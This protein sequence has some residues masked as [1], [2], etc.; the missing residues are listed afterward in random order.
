MNW[1]A[2]VILIDFMCLFFYI[3]A[4]L[5]L[6]IA[7][8][9]IMAFYEGKIPD[10]GVMIL[11]QLLLRGFLFAFVAILISETTQLTKWRTALLTGLTFSILGGIAPLLSTNELMPGFVRLGH[12][13]EVG[14]SNTLFGI[15]ASILIYR[16]PTDS[17]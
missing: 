1:A 7:A 3:G 4:G 6:S 10:M 5:V 2:K 9:Q 14:I 8:P 13:F 12:G 16:S 15:V 17:K 11:T